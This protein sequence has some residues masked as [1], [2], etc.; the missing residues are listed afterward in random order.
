MLLRRSTK[1]HH[2]ENYEYWTLVE[3]V[4]VSRGP[5][6]RVAATLG[7]LP[8]MDP[9]VRVGWEHIGGI[10]SWKLWQADFLNAPVIPA[11]A[12]ILATCRTQMWQ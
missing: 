11:F 7:K 3:S 12:G 9:E 2:G 8:G 4:R 1:E 5:R 10:L 6:Q